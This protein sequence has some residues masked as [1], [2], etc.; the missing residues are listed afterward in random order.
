MTLK[1]YRRMK[2][3][4]VFILAMFFAQSLQFENYLI[5]IA[6]L[7]IGAL[8]LAHLRRTVKEV[9]ADERDY[10]IGGK[11]AL[12][13]IQVYSWIAVTAMFIFYG[14]RDLNPSYESIGMTLAFST[15]IL[16][17]VYVTVFRY[18]ERISFTDKNFAYSLIVLLIFAA[19]FVAVVRGLSGEDGWI[20][21]DGKWVEHGH[22]DFAPPEIECE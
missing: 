1:E 5:P 13:A 2:I 12:L 21:V 6:V 4:I 7:A 20:C 15:T 19:L 17:L 18:Y 10:A 3:I 11:A 22:P 8:F 14:L 16:L 9:I